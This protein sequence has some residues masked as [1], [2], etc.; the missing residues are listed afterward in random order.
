[1]G[2]ATRAGCGYRCIKGNSPCRGCYGPPPGVID[3]G[4]RMMSAIASIVDE[5]EAADISRVLED[6]VDPAGFFYRFSL[7]SSLIRKK[8]S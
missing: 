1:M 7:P 4:T 6:V 2:P 3:P 5:K 8:I